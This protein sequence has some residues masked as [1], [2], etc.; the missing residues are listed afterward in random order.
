ML[1]GCA[2]TASAASLADSINTLRTRGCTAS[3]GVDRKLKQ[4]RALDEVARQWSRGGRLKQALERAE[5]RATNSSSMRVS[6]A[7]NDRAVID[8]LSRNYCRIITDPAFTEIG[9]ARRGGEAWMVVAAP[10]NLPSIRDAKQVEREV[11]QLVNAARAQARRCGGT[12]YS[13]AAPLKLSA[14]LNRA[15]LLHAQ[16]MA[17]H[18]HFEH[19]GTDGSTPSER[20]TR[21]GYRWRHV[22]ENIA[23]GAPT[24]A[25]VVDGWLNSPGHCANIMAPQY[26]EI[27]IA[28]ALESRSEAAIYWAQV[29]ATPR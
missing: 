24:A 23:A 14:T 28:F 4:T 17:R 10:L 18:S 3:A 13:P 15:A 6:G 8:L 19:V 9:I 7:A 12:A 16:D 27:G 11:L 29:F 1:L 20:V 22:A 2:A 26:Q 25:T 5:Y 21:V